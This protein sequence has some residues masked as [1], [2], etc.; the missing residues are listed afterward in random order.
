MLAQLLERRSFRWSLAVLSGILLV[1]SFPYT[2]SIFPLAFIAW[3][4][5]LLLESTYDQRRSHPLLLQSFLTFLIYN[6]GTTWWIYYASPEGAYMAF[7]CNSLVMTLAFYSYHRI[8]KKLGGHWGTLILLSVWIS[9]EFLHFNWEL[10]WP[11]LTLGN[12]FADVPMLVQWY[13]WTGVFGGTLWILSVNG[14]LYKLIRHIKI[15]KQPGL[16]VRIICGQLILL[17]MGPI[18]VSMFLYGTFSEEKNAYEVVVLQP[19]IDPYNEKFNGLSD[20]EQ[21]VRTMSLADTLVTRTTQLVVAPETALYPNYQIGEDDLHQLTAFHLLMERRARWHNASFLIGATTVKNFDYKN[22]P[23]ARKDPGGPGFTERYNSS[24]LFKEN[25]T[26]EIVH[27]SKL[28]LGVEKVPFTGIFP[29][30]E[31]LSI[32]L[33]GSGGSLGVQDEG[34]TV[35]KS[36]GVNFAPVVC[37]ESV[38]GGFVRSQCKQDAAFIAVITNDGWWRDTPG[39]KQHFAFSRLRAIENRKY[40][41][42]SANTG[43]SGIINGRGDVIRETGWWQEAAFRETIQL[44]R[45]KTIYEFL[46]DYIGYFAV[47]GMLVFIGMRIVKRLTAKTQSPQR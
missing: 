10:S 16:S 41:V 22:S 9:F 8:R 18:F 35:M 38:Y 24:V 32:S 36:R 33:E 15:Q 37:Y 2:G 4:P 3:V 17:L 44:S 43:K 1:I 21:L 46:G 14:L 20:E 13:A 34:P 45:R 7:L 40:V 5:L 30:L 26:P 6:V 12:V 23:A 28:V 31:E 11:W 25:R 19:N 29:Q 42:R 47:A 27:K 39:Y